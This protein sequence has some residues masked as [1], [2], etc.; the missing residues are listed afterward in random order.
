MMHSP[1]SHSYDSS[2][3]SPEFRRIFVERVHLL[4][5]RG[6]ER[7]VVADYVDE[8]EPEITGDLVKAIDGILD[9]RPKGWMRFFNA[10][11]ETPV[12]AAG[13]K[14]KRRNR[15][16]LRI[17]SAQRLPRSHYQFE[18]K[19][20]GKRNS[21]SQY[22]GQKG[23]GCFLRGDYARDEDEAGM[24]GY[25]QSGDLAE[26][27]TKINAALSDPATD[28]CLDSAIPFFEQSRSSTITMR[29][30]YSRHNR[31]T[32]GASIYITHLLLKFY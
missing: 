14:G 11:E 30:Y 12:N 8:E 6:Y 28:A 15:V 3:N 17:V 27:G 4:V 20:L 31:P 7:L 5:Q 26:W 23:L 24:L 29:K 16:D 9:N 2:S 22:L 32:V 13:R 18:A 19:R 25:V 21:V 1:R 10:H